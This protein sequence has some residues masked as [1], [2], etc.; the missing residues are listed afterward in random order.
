MKPNL[1]NKLHDFYQPPPPS[2]LPQ[3]TA[4]YMIFGVLA[5]CL[6]WLA[7]RISA[8]WRQNRYRRAALRQLYMIGASEIPELLKRTALAAWPR[9]QV[10]GLSGEP[11]VRFLEQHASTVQPHQEALNL[12]LDVAY[13][14]P[15][16]TFEEARALREFAAA[17]IRGHHVRA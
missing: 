9:E 17:W 14:C 8:R 5:L 6:G 3:T 11:W 13:R 4:W 12:L 2:W 15:K 1:L 10:A 7:W 16:L